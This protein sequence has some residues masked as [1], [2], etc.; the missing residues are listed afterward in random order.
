MGIRDQPQMGAGE[1]LLG[2]YRAVTEDVRAAYLAVLG[3]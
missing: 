3:L 1:G 2:R